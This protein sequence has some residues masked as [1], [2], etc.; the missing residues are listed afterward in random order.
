MPR[1]I[2]ERTPE[3]RAKMSAATLRRWGNQ[4]RRYWSHVKR[5]PGCWTWIGTRDNHGYGVVYFDGRLQKAHRVAWQLAHGTITP[6]ASVCHR[7]DNPPCVNPTH[8]FLG[9]Q[10]DNMADMARKGRGVGGPGAK[11]GE[12]H[13]MAKLSDVDVQTIRDLQESGWTQRSIAEKFSV[14]Q[15]NISMI[16]SG[17]RRS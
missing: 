10:A 8:L 15:G 17:R 7:C 12:A 11:R 3:Y 1:G 14:S 13:H 2:Y 16:L 6:G 4:E 9:T 5:S